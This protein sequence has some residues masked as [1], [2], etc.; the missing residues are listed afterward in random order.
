MCFLLGNN[1]LL[2]AYKEYFEITRGGDMRM[3][4]HSTTSYYYCHQ[5]RTS[6][7]SMSQCEKNVKK[8]EDDKS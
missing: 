7:D 2:Q 8:S 3:A 1:A 5:R 4:H 6:W